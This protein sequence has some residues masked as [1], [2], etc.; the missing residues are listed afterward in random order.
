[1]LGEGLLALAALAG[2]MVV[3]AAD[4]DGWKT[5]EHGYPKLLGRGNATQTR[6]AEQWLKE[7][8][9]QLAGHN[10]ADTDIIRLALAGRWSG[11][12]ADLLE[13]NP[14]AE[15]E[16]RILVQEI[17]ET[18]P[19][20]TVVASGEV[21]PEAAEASAFEAGPD[22]PG[23][24]AS[25]SELAYSIGQAGD[26]A[27]A[28]DQFAQLVT[29]AERILGPNHPDTLAARASL[30][31][32]TGQAG[33][34][35]T[36]R[37]QFDELVPVAE[38]ILGPEHPDTLINRHN[39]ANFAGYAGDAAAARD[40][41]A[42]LLRVRERVF[43][44]ES[45]DT[46]MARFNLAYWTG[47]AGAPAPPGTSSPS[48]F[49]SASGCMAR[50]TLTPWRCGRNWPTGRGAPGPRPPPGTSSRRCC[51]STNASSVQST[52]TP[53][54]CGT[55]SPT[56]A[57][58]PGTSLSRLL[59]TERR[60]RPRVMRTTSPKA[61]QT[62]SATATGTPCARAQATGTPCARA[63]AMAISMA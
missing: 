7:T 46:L 10:G 20:G 19:A 22:H 17:Q 13:E 50:T 45:P 21:P 38:E 49:P 52:P 34:A 26:A 23:A 15:A 18:L 62:P 43:G 33:D 30:A 16:L 25:Q 5:V 57:R 4:T 44:Q 51:P 58:W 14:G 3:A 2:Q 63:Q 61:S 53:W 27:G 47:R 8:R 55:S 1:M 6:M 9:E 42:I 40:Q 37:E 59:R 48:C 56:G 54:P 11:R 12:L 35:A 39:L 41:F 24:L 31:Y 36:A 28:R 60:L 29:A 32:W